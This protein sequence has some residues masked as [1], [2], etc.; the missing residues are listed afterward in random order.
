ML[1]SDVESLSRRRFS[2]EEETMW[3]TTGDELESF[4]LE[5]FFSSSSH[6]HTSPAFTSDSPCKATRLYHEYSQELR[7]YS[8]WASKAEDYHDLLAVGLC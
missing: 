1:E 6:N 7:Q 5:A 2:G 3:R 4:L 8:S